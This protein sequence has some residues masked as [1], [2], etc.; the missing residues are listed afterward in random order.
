[1]YLSTGKAPI[2]SWSQSGMQHLNAHASRLCGRIREAALFDFG[3]DEDDNVQYGRGGK[4]ANT[5]DSP[6]AYQRL[7]TSACSAGNIQ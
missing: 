3:H 4:T 2:P 5:R 1:M 6:A 7:N